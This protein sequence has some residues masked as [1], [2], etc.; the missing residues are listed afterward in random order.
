MFNRFYG[1]IQARW[2]ELYFPALKL[3]ITATC[4]YE[5]NGVIYLVNKTVLP[6][7]ATS[8]T[9]TG[10]APGSEC[11]F[12]LKAVYNPASIDEGIS[13][14]YMVLPMSKSLICTFSYTFY[15]LR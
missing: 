2:N 10:L 11:D 7:N 3:E 12:T 14:T 1:S 9:F 13:V 5:C 8:F 15:Q 6:P 4:K